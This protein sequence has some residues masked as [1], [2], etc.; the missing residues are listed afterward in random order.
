ME[1]RSNNACELLGDSAANSNFQR[2]KQITPQ[3]I[4]LEAPT[5]YDGAR[6]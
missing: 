4:D 6:A 3:S 5:G 2:Q 1:M